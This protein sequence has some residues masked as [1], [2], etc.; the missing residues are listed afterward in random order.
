MTNKSIRDF[1]LPNLAFW[2][3]YYGIS[4]F[5]APNFLIIGFG[6]RIVYVLIFLLGLAFMTGGYRFVYNY[7]NFSEKTAYF[8]FLQVFLSGC[9][10]M[11]LDYLYRFKIIPFLLYDIFANLFS[12]DLSNPYYRVI[13]QTEYNKDVALYVN[14]ASFSNQMTKFFAIMCWL[15]AYNFYKSYTTAQKRRISAL[16][17]ETQAQEAELATLRAQLN[18]HFLFNSLNSIH[19]M[20]LTGN[21]K[22]SDAVL[23]LADLMRYTLNY[24]KKNLVT[25]AEELDIVDKYLGLEKIR[26][27]KK[28]SYNLDI[29][30]DTLDKNMPPIVLQ[31]L[32]ENAIKHSVSKN[33]EGGQLT[34]RTQLDA[35]NLR[36]EVINT[37]QL[38]VL[39]DTKNG[40]IGIENTKRRLAMLYADKASFAIQ[41][42]NEHE[43]IAT[44]RLP[45]S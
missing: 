30:K 23:L 29:Q 10:L 1:W 42:L 20:A 5:T 45:L 33:T 13:T 22:A 34:V 6:E 9:S 14:A 4:I 41:N 19:S 39:K 28:L 25:V 12:K 36:L 32:V 11:L 8:S 38:Q 17:S 37:G 7:F 31:T 35:Q 27:G 3:F 40:G 44:V 15:V 43:V 16:R 2:L 18:P 24:E 26:F 21:P